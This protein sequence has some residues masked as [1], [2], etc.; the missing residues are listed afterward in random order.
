MQCVC[1]EP[2]SN[3]HVQEIHRGHGHG[4]FCFDGR[5]ILLYIWENNQTLQRGVGDMEMQAEDFFT[6]LQR[7]N[8]D[9][10]LY[11]FDQHFAERSPALAEDYS[12]PAVFPQ[13]FGTLLRTSFT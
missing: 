2:A 6:Y 11:L 7:Q 10:P 9:S 4:L 13:P 5:R 12:T 1:T 3:C 8:D